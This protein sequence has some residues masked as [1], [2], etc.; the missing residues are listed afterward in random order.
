LFQLFTTPPLLD[1]RRVDL[2]LM[3]N[4]T[5]PALLRFSDKDTEQPSPALVLR[6]LPHDQ[7][8]NVVHKYGCRACISS[9][10]RNDL[11]SE[12]DAPVT[13]AP[14]IVLMCCLGQRFSR[15]LRQTATRITTPRQPKNPQSRP[16]NSIPDMQTPLVSG[17]ERPRVAVLFQAIDSPAYDGVR[18]PRKPGG[19]AERESC[20]RTNILLIG[21]R[22]SR[23]GRGHCVRTPAPRSSRRDNALPVSRPEARPRVVLP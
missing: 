4:P 19:T 16:F 5:S 23:L 7:T 18:K 8:C 6:P 13:Y 21:N 11:S 2:T 1:P 12:S 14:S 10:A 22:L 9:H 20:H 3:L 15:A 17:Q